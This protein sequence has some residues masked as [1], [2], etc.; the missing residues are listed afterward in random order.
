MTDAA[1]NGA[2]PQPELTAQLLGTPAPR[3]VRL[4]ASARLTELSAAYERFASSADGVGD[5]L[6][7]LRV[8]LRRL[9]SWLRAF[10]REVDDTVRRKTRRR[11]SALAE[12]TNGAR[13]AEVALEWITMQTDLSARERAGSGYV[14]SRLRHECD[15]G[16]RA[17]RE[18]LENDLPKLVD[19]LSEQLASYWQRQS[20]AEPS[21]P[22]STAAVTG[23]ALID[24]GKRLARAI[25][26][27]ASPGEFDAAHR[28]RIAAK[29]LRYLL[30]TLNGKP[31][32]A[33][34]V[35]RLTDL[36]DVLGIVHDSHRIANRLVREIGECAA[37][38][39]RRVAMHA[40]ARTDDDDDE[41]E[42]QPPFSR[43]RPGLTALA[44][45]AQRSEQEAYAR[46]RRR[47]RKRQVES[48]LAALEQVA[49]TL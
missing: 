17:A 3:A 48:T 21:A 38:D 4:I 22:K 33:A 10:R 45:R 27:A 34:L 20:V 16:F 7:D 31:A 11:L 24:H 29:R 9:R 8:A 19:S 23:E 37:R 32:T 44:H 35:K 28:A 30:E 2:A 43:I 13:D 1:K 36:Q 12:A 25:D 46:F 26:R 42:E 15:A 18:A 49:E 5:G 39:A 40:L 47:W 6:H 14:A 41:D